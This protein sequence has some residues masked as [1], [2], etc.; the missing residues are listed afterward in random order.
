M[1][2]WH[3]RDA[4]PLAAESPYTFYKPSR[5]VIAKVAVGEV[6]KLIFAFEPSGPDAPSAERM[7][8]TVDEICPDGSFVGR[9]DNDPACIVDLKHGEKI[10]FSACHIIATDHD[11][12]DNLVEKYIKR[13]FVTNRVLQDGKP[14]GLL[15]REDP[16]CDDD[17]GWRITAN[18]ESKAYLANSNNL[19]Y[20]SLGAVLRRDDS[21]RSLLDAAAGSAFVRRLGSQTFEP[22]TLK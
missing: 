3:L 16:D 19:A 14:V 17:S 11:D 13:C 12:A 21:F 5:E 6:V 20:V 18:D 10:T 2:S 9:L 7:W 4:D 8:V 15:Y 22:A 1:A